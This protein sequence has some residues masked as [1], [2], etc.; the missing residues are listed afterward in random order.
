M[1]VIIADQTETHSLLH[2]DNSC[3]QTSEEKIKNVRGYIYDSENNLVC[4]SFSY[5]PEYVVGVDKDKYEPLLTDLSKCFIYKSEEGTLLRLFFNQ[6]RWVLSTHKRI[7]A[8]DSK[9]SSS[10]SFGEL[11]IDALLHFFTV[12]GKDKLTFENNEELFDQ[13]CNTLDREHVYTF[14]VRTNKDTK[15]VCNPPEHPTLYFSGW[16]KDG[17]WQETNPTIIPTPTLLS[18]SSI[19][20]LE[21]YVEG[22][23][24]LEHQGTIII[25]PDRTT[26][27]IMCVLNMEYKSVRGSEPDIK[28]TYFR[29]L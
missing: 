4:S 1:S 29:D 11:F 22:V 21:T 16:F 8:F 24:P 12:E 15:I 14:L 20:E 26:L 2:Y 23:D 6:N 28:E 25:L 9:W 27:K 13:F 5:T 17:V 10:K 18:F 3:D 7:N 19:K